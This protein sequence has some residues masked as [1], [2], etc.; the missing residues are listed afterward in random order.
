MAFLKVHS[1]FMENSF[2]TSGIPSKIFTVTSPYIRVFL[3]FLEQC[4]WILLEFAFYQLVFL[5]R[6]LGQKSDSK[7]R[8]TLVTNKKKTYS[9]SLKQKNRKKNC[10]GYQKIKDPKGKRKKKRDFYNSCV[11]SRIFCRESQRSSFHYND[12]NV[13]QSDNMRRGKYFS[14]SDF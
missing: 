3:L 7:F 12:R 9:S 8:N 11:A 10:L 14:L 4:S 2:K 5:H 13:A 6:F 1:S